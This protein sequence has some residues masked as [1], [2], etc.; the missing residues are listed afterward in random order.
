MLQLRLAELASIADDVF[1]LEKKI[2][3]CHLR[4]KR[5]FANSMKQL[6]VLLFRP[7]DGMLVRCIVAI[8][9]K[10]LSLVPIFTPGLRVN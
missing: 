5:T 10:F 6:G 4:L 7:L 9:I 2:G 1:Q 3:M 8:S